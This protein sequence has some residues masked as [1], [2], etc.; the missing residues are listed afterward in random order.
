LF[1]GNRKVLAKKKRGDEE[2][3]RLESNII[4]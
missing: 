1:I 4:L 2:E 3:R